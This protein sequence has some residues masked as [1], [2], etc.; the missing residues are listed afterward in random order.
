MFLF[1]EISSAHSEPPVHRPSPKMLFLPSPKYPIAFILVT[2][3]ISPVL[4]A[5][6]DTATCT[7]VTTPEID[8]GWE[9]LQVTMVLPRTY[10]ASGSA[11]DDTITAD[12]Y[13]CNDDFL[14][15]LRNEAMVSTPHSKYDS[16]REEDGTCV[17]KARTRFVEMVLWVFNRFCVFDLLGLEKPVCRE[18][19][20]VDAVDDGDA[21]DEDDT[22]G[23]DDTAD[24]DD[25]GIL[26]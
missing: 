3:F 5:R 11:P 19:G 2:I 18:E 16:I 8:A 23:D 15:L 10:L 20:E 24:D 7:Y 6:P 13:F 4:A 14:E 22:V 25:N 21:V 12:Q 26:F 9:V 17:I 1:Q